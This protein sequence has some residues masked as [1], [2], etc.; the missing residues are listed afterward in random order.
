M[1]YVAILVRP[2]QD[3]CDP[4]EEVQTV[5]H[6]HQNCPEPNENVELLVE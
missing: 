6:G 5:G 2:K 1:L 4:R 3:P